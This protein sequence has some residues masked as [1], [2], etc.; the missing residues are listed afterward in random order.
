MLMVQRF[1]CSFCHIYRRLLPD[2]LAPH[3]HYDVDLIAAA[4]DGEITSETI[5]YISYPSERTIARWKEWFAQN[6]PEIENR[7]GTVR[8][9][10]LALNLAILF[11]LYAPLSEMRSRL[12]NWLS[13]LLQATYNTGGSLEPLRERQSPESRGSPAAPTL[14]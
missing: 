9:R 6:E 11:A 1:Q 8:M 7:L 13:V 10:L 4:I 14:L 3:K 2:D 5:E 12:N